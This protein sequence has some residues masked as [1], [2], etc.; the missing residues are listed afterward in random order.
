MIEAGV[1]IDRAMNPIFW[2]LPEGRTAGSIPDTRVLWDV[3]WER[4]AEPCPPWGVHSYTTKA[5]VQYQY[6]GM[7]IAPEPSWANDLRKLSA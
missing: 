5:G 4:L 1:V 7:V 3:L 2:H 6:L